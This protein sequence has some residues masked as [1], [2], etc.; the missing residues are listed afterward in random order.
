MEMKALLP[1]KAATG[2]MAGAAVYLGIAF[3][4]SSDWIVTFGTILGGLGWLAWWCAC[5]SQDLEER[6][7]ERAAPTREAA[8]EIS[9]VSS[10]RGGSGAIHTN[11]DAKRAQAGPESGEAPS[12]ETEN[13]E[14]LAMQL[15]LALTESE[16][17]VSIAIASFSEVTI[18]AQDITEC[19]AEMKNWYTEAN[20]LV[21]N[22]LGHVSECSHTI[23]QRIGLIVKTFQFHDL[24][25]QR[26]E[27]TAA[28][29]DGASPSGDKEKLFHAPAL[30]AADYGRENQD[31]TTLF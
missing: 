12:K 3:W 8:S 18:A 22:T 27:Y 11:S 30:Q 2:I 29:L 17:A 9:T 16:Q 21:Q 7:E 23:N 14:A 5:R 20:P 26:L 6:C 28:V 4:R 10:G 24:L 19:M 31:S 15:R 25:Q 13:P 1:D